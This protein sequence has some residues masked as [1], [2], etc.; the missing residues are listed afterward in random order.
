M[1]RSS[2][3]D[4]LPPLE[5]QSVDYLAETVLAPLRAV[6]FWLAI[7]LPFLYVPLLVTGLSD[8]TLIGAF[9][10]LLAANVVAL[11]AGHSY[12]RE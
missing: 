5:R 1:P 2:R 11:L 9:L 7:A 8:A 10:V 4:L 6:A 3:F 12:L